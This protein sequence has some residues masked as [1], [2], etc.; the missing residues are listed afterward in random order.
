MWKYIC[1]YGRIPREFFTKGVYVHHF[2]K[3]YIDI[4]YLVDFNIHKLKNIYVHI[5]YQIDNLE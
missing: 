3:V 1:I 2:L 4:K 5:H